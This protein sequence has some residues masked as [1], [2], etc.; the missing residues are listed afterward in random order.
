MPNTSWSYHK[1]QECLWG[2]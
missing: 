2:G 1:H